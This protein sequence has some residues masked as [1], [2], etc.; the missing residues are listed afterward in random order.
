MSSEQS[1]R[2]SRLQPPSCRDGKPKT[3]PRLK[4]NHDVISELE[5][6]GVDVFMPTSDDSSLADDFEDFANFVLHERNKEECLSIILDDEHDSVGQLQ[7]GTESCSIFRL[8]FEE[9]A[10]TSRGNEYAATLLLEYF[11]SSTRRTCSRSA[12]TTAKI[13]QYMLA[14]C[15]RRCRERNLDI[16]YNCLG[17]CMFIIQFGGPTN[18]QVRHID[19]MLPN[20]QGETIYIHVISLPHNPTDILSSLLVYVKELPEHHR[21]C[22]G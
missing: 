15:N 16:E 17:N 10:P 2:C 8:S 1:E 20:L 19:N 14:M 22:I 11:N 21:L 4:S 9:D 5:L 12:L 18:G 3:Y 13:R 6:M 7:G